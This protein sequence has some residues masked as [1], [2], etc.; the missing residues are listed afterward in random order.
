M[1]RRSVG[2]VKTQFGGNPERGRFVR[3]DKAHRFA[4]RQNLIPPA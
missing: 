1:V 2:R 3:I 4:R